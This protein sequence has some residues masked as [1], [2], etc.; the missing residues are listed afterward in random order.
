M[1]YTSEKV[2]VTSVEGAV[3]ALLNPN[4]ATRFLGWTSLAAKGEK[5]ETALLSLW[6]SDNGFHRAQALWLLAKYPKAIRI[7]MKGL[8]M[9]IQI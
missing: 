5:A 8:R 9:P 4:I 6:K 2:D 1:K 3:I 7:W